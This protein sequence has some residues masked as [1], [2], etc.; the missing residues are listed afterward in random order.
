[1]FPNSLNKTLCFIYCLN[2]RYKRYG[3]VLFKNNL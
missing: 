1:M 3:Y 2:G